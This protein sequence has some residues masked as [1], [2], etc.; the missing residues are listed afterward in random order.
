[1]MKSENAEALAKSTTLSI[2]EQ[3]IFASAAV[4]LP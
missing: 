4:V 3:K 2:R 1:M